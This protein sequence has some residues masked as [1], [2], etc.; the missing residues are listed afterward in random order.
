MIAIDT[1]IVVHLL[2]ADDPTQTAYAA[3]GTASEF[4]TFDRALARHA[5]ALGVIPA[6]RLCGG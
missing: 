5:A 6:V 1:N 2:V 3:A 4:A